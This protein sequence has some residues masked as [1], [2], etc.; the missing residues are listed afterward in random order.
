MLWNLK[1]DIDLDVRTIA[2]SG[3]NQNSSSELTLTPPIISDEYQPNYD[4]EI[5][6]INVDTSHKINADNIQCEYVVSSDGLPV[7]VKDQIEA[8][9]RKIDYVREAEE[10]F[11]QN[12]VKKLIALTLTFS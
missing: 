1:R 3:N 9:L 7:L 10:L 5:E 12:L 2:M 11:V 8:N 4:Y 6:Y